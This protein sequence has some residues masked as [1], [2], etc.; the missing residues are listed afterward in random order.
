MFLLAMRCI[1]SVN[2][3]HTATDRQTDGRQTGR[4]GDRPRTD[5]QVHPT[6]CQLRLCCV[7]LLPSAASAHIYQHYLTNY[8]CNLIYPVIFYVRKIRDSREK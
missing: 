3:R 8:K 4:L 5:T 7:N 1:I 6:V 2:L